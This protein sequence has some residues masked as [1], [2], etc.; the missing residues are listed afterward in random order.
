VLVTGGAGFVGRAVIRE[1][2]AETN[3]LGPCT[4]RVLDTA[5]G[6]HLDGLGV[7]HIRADV[8]NSDAVLSAAS[9]ADIVMNLAS[10]VDWGTRPRSEVF[11]VNV[12]GTRSVVDASRRAGVKALV[13]T[14]SLDAICS[15]KPI[16]N[17]DET[18]PYPDRWP[19][20]YCESK[21]R[22]EQLVIEADGDGMRTV[23]L[24]P[25]DVYG[26]ADPYHVS[27]L[28]AMAKSGPYVRIGDGS[29]RCM[30]I[31]AGNVAHA[32]VVAA[33]AIMRGE[34]GH[35][36]K[37]YFLTDSAPSNFFA[38]F[39]EIVRIAGYRIWPRNVWLPRG[40]MY[41][42]GCIAEAV[43]WTVRPVVRLNPRLSRFAV[44]YTCNEFTLNG[45]AAR[46]DFGYEPKYS[47]EE[48]VARTA[49]WFREHGPVLPN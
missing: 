42:A 23:A 28:V 6:S 46:R 44:E 34:T 15:G 17:A 49:D 31:Y 10:I 4:V 40:L 13:H 21:A 19:N 26:E 36:G 29:A 22:S 27:S 12:D 41:A 25:C 33:A 5:E 18:T 11:S 32:L 48:A 16:H 39:D 30:H 47:V 14:S 43:A 20:A 37:A 24:R 2:L 45:D 9:G 3:P 35:C 7:E 8:R 1:L 38:F